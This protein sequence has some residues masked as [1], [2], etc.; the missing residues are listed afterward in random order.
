[1]TLLWYLQPDGLHIYLVHA[2]G[3]STYNINRYKFD[4]V[5]KSAL[6]NSTFKTIINLLRLK[7]PNDGLENLQECLEHARS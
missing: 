2:C 1:M 7:S 3:I 6:S 4:N 5:S